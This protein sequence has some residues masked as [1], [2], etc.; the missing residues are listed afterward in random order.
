MK[1]VLFVAVASAGIGVGALIADQ[2]LRVLK[3]IDD[4]YDVWDEEGE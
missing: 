2:L 1:F 4:S 3:S